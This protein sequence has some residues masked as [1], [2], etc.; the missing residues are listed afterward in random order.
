MLSTSRGPAAVELAALAGLDLDD[1]QRL[2]LG[3]GL[4]YHPG[5]RWATPEVAVIEPR[6]NG[7][8]WTLAVRVLAGLYLFGE[9]EIVWTAHRFSTAVDAWRLLVGLVTGSEHLSSRVRSTPKNALDCGIYLNTGAAVRF[10]ARTGVAI[11]GKSPDCVILDEA[12]ALT[13]DHLAAILPALSARPNSQVWYGS[14]APFPGSEVLRRLCLRGRAGS[15]G[16]A[17]LEWCADQD[18]ASDDPQAWRQA[19]PAMGSGRSDA[20]TET[21]IRRELGAQAESDFRRERLG[22]WHESESPEWLAI[23]EDA[24]SAA[25]ADPARPASRLRDPVALGVWVASDRSWSAIAA[26]GRRADGRRGV[27]ITRDSEANKQDYRPG[28]GWLVDRLGALDRRHQPAVIVVGDKAIADQAESA[29]LA[30]VRAHPADQAAAAATLYDGLCGDR[31]DVCHIGQRELRTAAA[32][33]EQ[34]RSGAVWYWTSE[35]ADIAPLWA[36]SLAL[37]GLATTRVHRKQALTPFALI[38][39]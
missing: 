19:N 30:V 36:G 21:T 28:T 10:L 31:P 18:A 34:R 16:L 11:R 37:W 38:G 29:G 7:K 22:I 39:D 35:G 26:A 17:Y 9:R 8:T 24:W 6:Q 23:R 27:E 32:A 25:Q 20:P 2:V 5:G 15:E 33:A 14:S 13:D 1:A 12:F 4:G 3:D